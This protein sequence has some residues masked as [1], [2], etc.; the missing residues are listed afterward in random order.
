MILTEHEQVII[1]NMRHPSIRTV[2]ASKSYK[3]LSDEEL[4]SLI[5]KIDDYVNEI[6][7]TQRAFSNY[8]EF[9]VL[10]FDSIKARLVDECKRRKIMFRM[11]GDKFDVY[12]KEYNEIVNS[13]MNHPVGNIMYKIRQIKRILMEEFPGEANDEKAELVANRLYDQIMY[14]DKDV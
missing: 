4:T 12:R 11:Q 2:T 3:D 5:G 7:E 8:D 10:E 13:A 1:N 6:G 9:Y 14:E